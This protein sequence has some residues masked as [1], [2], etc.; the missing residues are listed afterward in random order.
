MV[1]ENGVRLQAGNSQ[2]EIDPLFDRRVTRHTGIDHFD[3]PARVRGSQLRF[4]QRRP[5]LFVRSCPFPAK[6]RRFP[7][8]ENAKG[9]RRFGHLDFRAAKSQTVDVDT[10][11]PGLEADTWN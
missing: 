2:H 8:S 5:R 4:Q 3:L 7:Q 10:E 1:D 11:R 9:S 6:S